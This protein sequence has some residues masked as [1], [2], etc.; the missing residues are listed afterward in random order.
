MMIRMCVE[1]NDCGKVTEHYFSGVLRNNYQL[2][3]CEN[4]HH[5]VWILTINSELPKEKTKEMSRDENKTTDL[6]P[7]TI[8]IET[9]EKLL[10][11]EP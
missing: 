8:N 6:K 5:K 3:E 7:L 11:V 2:F 4:C 10:L 1:C 9:P